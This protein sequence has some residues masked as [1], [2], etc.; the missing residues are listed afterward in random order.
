MKKQIVS[1][2]LLLVI[3]ASSC[4]TTTMI[5]SSWRKPNATVNNFK[6]IFVTALTS[7]IAA[8]QAVENGLQ[9]HLQEKGLTVAKGIDVFP[10]N[11]ASQNTQQRNMVWSKI[12][13]TGAE[14]ILTIALLKK[15]T[16]TRFVP[17]GRSYW[18][19]GLRYGY[20]NSFWNYYNRWYPDLYAAGY[21]D[22]DQVYYLE[23]NL[24]DGRNEELL[25][26]AQSKTYEASSIDSFLKGYLKTI[27]QQ[28]QK[29][30]LISSQPSASK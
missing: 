22:S 23:T 24:Y 18:N 17:T 12:R 10:P 5:T 13:A 26:T 1:T 14:G 15:E 30:G 2:L 3:I 7:N 29:D 6:T 25:W 9:T 28:M 19:P 20:Y 27:Y 21:Y 4:G 11:F 8:K 16:E